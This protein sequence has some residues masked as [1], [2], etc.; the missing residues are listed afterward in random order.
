MNIEL[1]AFHAPAYFLVITFGLLF[2]GIKGPRLMLQDYPKAIQNATTPKTKEEKRLG[3]L[4][5]LPFI[6]AFIS[7][8]FGLGFHVAKSNGNYWYVLEHVYVLLFLGNLYDLLI[9]DW[10]VFCY[11]TP[12]IMVIPG[13]E[14]NPGYKDYKFHFIGFLKGLLITAVIAIILSGIVKLLI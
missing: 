10:L 8:P 2:I 7:Y 14:G 5:G 3:I 11:I 13:T 12:K 1:I 9:I 4:F 6:L